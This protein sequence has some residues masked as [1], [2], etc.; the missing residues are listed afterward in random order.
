MFRQCR[1]I[2]SLAI[3]ACVA[4]CSADSTLTVRDEQV[5]RD[6]GSTVRLIATDA[7][8]SM[9]FCSAVLVSPSDLLT[10]EHCLPRDW[11]ATTITPHDAD[12]IDIA[13]RVVA[14]ISLGPEL[15]LRH[16]RIARRGTQ[17][18]DWVHLR[19]A[20]DS[21]LL[22]D[23]VAPYDAELPLTVGDMI[24]LAGYPALS[25]RPGEAIPSLTVFRGR[26]V[27][28]LPDAVRIR[29]VNEQGSSPPLKPG[30]GGRLVGL[31]GGAAF[32]LLGG[33]PITVGVCTQAEAS[34]VPIIASTDT[35]VLIVRPPNL[36]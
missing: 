24:Y 22:A 16:F 30:I 32:I 26:V 35:E 36:P 10:C 15:H 11:L 17:S 4:A 12:P 8:G 27:Q 2:L 13:S 31:S 1:I 6:A 7:T 33:R 9:A 23:H 28:T 3:V 5:L 25:V 14:P 21:P 18:A 29:L 34:G 19:L 20:D